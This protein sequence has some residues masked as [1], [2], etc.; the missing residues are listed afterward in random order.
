VEGDID[1]GGIL[2]ISSGEVRNGYRQ[3]REVTDAQASFAWTLDEARAH[4]QALAR[5]MARE[6]DL[7]RALD[8]AEP[9]AAA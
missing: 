1:L 7:L 6:A 2:G 9:A 5:H 4:H 3:I 8:R